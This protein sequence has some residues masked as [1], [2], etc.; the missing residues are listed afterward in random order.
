MIQAIPKYSI[1]LVSVLIL[2]GCANITPGYGTFVPNQN[3]P[4]SLESFQIDPDMNYYFS[5]PYLRPDAIIGVNKAYKLNSTLWNKIVVTPELIERFV[6]GIKSLPSSISLNSCAMLDDKGKQIG[7]WYSNFGVRSYIKMED[8]RTVDI[9]TPI[10]PA[11]SE[12]MN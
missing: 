1:L 2:F 7:V 3:A 6:S 12:L 9:A 10:N 5:G 4:M 8:E 11:R